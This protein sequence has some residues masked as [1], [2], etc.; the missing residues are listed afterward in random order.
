MNFI[1]NFYGGKG[2]ILYYQKLTEMIIVVVRSSYWGS[3]DCPIRPRELW[4]YRDVKLILVHPEL[5][6]YTV[7]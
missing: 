2:S 1:L 7:K 4:Q 6:Y 3:E 5:A